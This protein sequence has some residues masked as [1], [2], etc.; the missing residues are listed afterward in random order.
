LHFLLSL[1]IIFTQVALPLGALIVAVQPTPQM[2][3]ATVQQ[4]GLG[5]Q[6]AQRAGDLAAWAQPLVG[7]P[8]SASAQGSAPTH[9]LIGI[10]VEGSGASKVCAVTG[11]GGVLC[12]GYSN[13][14]EAFGD[15]GSSQW[16]AVPVSVVGVSDAVEVAVGEGWNCA[17]T[18]SGAVQCWGVN[19]YFGL[20][21]PT[22]VAMPFFTSGVTSIASD[23][24][25]LCALLTTGGVQCVGGNVRGDLGN[26]TGTASSTPVN[27]TGLSSGVAALTSGRWTFC[28]ITTGGGAKCW[29]Y[30]VNGHTPVDVSG[31]TS[32]VL[33]LAVNTTNGCAVV[34]GNTVKCWGSNASGSLGDNTI[35]E[36]LTPAPVLNLTNA[37][38]IAVNDVGTSC[39]TLSTGGAMCWG[40]NSSGAA[41]VL[42]DYTSFKLPVMV[43]GLSSTL[44]QII[45]NSAAMCAVT[46]TGTPLC[47]G[48][49]YHDLTGTGMDRTYQVYPIAPA[50]LVGGLAA[51]AP[52]LS[53]GKRGPASATQ[54]I[55]Y[56]YT[57]VVTNTGTV[58]TSGTIT[59]TDSLTT[60]L[61]F[62][63]GGGFT[64]SA[65]GQD[66]TC[67][68]S[69]TLAIS[70]TATITLTVSPT[71]TG[72][73][74]NTASVV[75]GGDT[76][77]ATSNTVNTIVSA[78]ITPGIEYK[79]VYNSTSGLYEVWMR[80]T[81]TPG[82]PGT[83]G[84]AQVTI[85][86]PH[87]MGTGVFSPTTIT[88][89]VTDTAWAIGSRTDAPTADT[90]AD[91]I[92]FE[93]DF[94]TNNNAAINWQGGQ[95]I[96]LFTFANGG[97]CAGPVTLMEDGDG[98]NAPP[99]NPGQQI[100]VFGLGS[101]PAN[102]FLGNYGLGQSDCDRD[103]DGIPNDL[104][105][106]DDGDG[107]PDS[108]EGDLTVDTDGDGIPDRI[109]ADSDGDGIPDN[110]EAQ[111][112]TGYVAPTGSDTDGDGI[113]NAYDA[114][115]AGTPLTTPVNTDGTDNPDYLDPD[116]D[117]EGG[118]DTTEAG[119]T[120]T[121][122][123]VDKDGLDDGV[124]TN[125]G[126]FGPVNLGITDPAATYPDGDSDAGS[127]GDVDFRDAIN[128]LS[129]TLPIKL[130][131]G[132]AYQS[133][134]GLM[135]AT[136]R[137]LPDFPLTSPYGGGETT[138]SR[139]IL[140]A[141]NIVDWVI[142]ELRSSTAMTTVVTTAAALL[143]AD[144]DVVGLDGTST[145]TFTVAAD[146]Y[147]VA[148]NHR[149]H[150]GVMTANPI[151]LT[152]ATAL[153][154]LTQTSTLIYGTHA[155]QIHSSTGV[156][157]LWAGDA[158]QDGQVIAAG[159]SNDRNPLLVKA[160]LAP[161]N[162]AYAVNYIV[163]GYAPT[164]LNLDGVTLASGP[165]NDDNVILSNLFSHPDNGNSATNFIVEEQLP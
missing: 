124:D 154:D 157:M 66:V 9:R 102:D 111:T 152:A 52:D 71:M 115:Q 146:N 21:S 89:Q 114:D 1:M 101:D 61:S 104:D 161:G 41:G 137:T 94:P 51:P 39:A 88:A 68:S 24:A 125:T 132:G 150:L 37:T 112:T 75:G 73:V 15:G 55:N 42:Y 70:D 6:L 82:A 40:S 120:L 27:V 87:V 53:I 165:D 2:V 46:D 72:T 110:I 25:S 108:V 130:I 164:D 5:D 93:L 76:S 91:Y 12:W 8:H 145:L 34:T 129:V 133:N 86:A 81:V 4:A 99:N 135:H 29:G 17:L 117:N 78:P 131:L 23:G 143:Q 44:T 127:G 3:Q 11:T 50:G 45:G 60:G 56:D 85:K 109:D 134:S 142:V 62:V 106:D 65:V 97:V 48:Y 147:Y 163:S 158:N 148:L 162:S 64:C 156:A 59:V 140:T 84:T 63:S 90:S 113:D 74:S 69:A 107:I 153:L 123:D 7:Q 49:A 43:Q 79:L 38:H 26:G 67:T 95:E 47:W 121:G 119:L 20:N 116:S 92:S 54:N 16:R 155:R 103:G 96:L 18:S 136:L 31:L 118:D 100:D 10:S 139:T 36:H 98:F 159:P 57:L 122:V 28:V 77:A 138:T 151:M 22:A 35:I 19:S 105:A 126:L 30:N 13:K 58:A 128:D 14:P 144:G 83:T 141:N 160:F 32:G 33:E 80:S 149:N